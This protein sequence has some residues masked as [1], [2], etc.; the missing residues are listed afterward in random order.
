M[1]PVP[2]HPF[3]GAGAGNDDHET[4]CLFIIHPP[5]PDYQNFADYRLTPDSAGWMGWDIERG[6]PAEPTPRWGGRVFGTVFAVPATI[7]PYRHEKSIA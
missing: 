2:P 1:S 5:M 3:P 4:C 7:V 6:L